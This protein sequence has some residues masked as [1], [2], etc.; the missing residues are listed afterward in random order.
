MDRL[1][2]IKDWKANLE[3]ARFAGLR[4][5]Q[6]DGRSVEYRTDAEMRQAIADLNREI[7][8]AEGRPPVSTIKF[9]G[10]KGL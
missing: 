7:A 1:T 8:A 6:R 2:Q 3:A 5:V 4:V 9:Y 10:S